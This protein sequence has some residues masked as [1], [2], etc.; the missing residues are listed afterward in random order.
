M[1]AEQNKHLWD[2]EMAER[3]GD[4]DDRWPEGDEFSFD[5]EAMIDELF[6]PRDEE[7]AMEGLTPEESKLLKEKYDGNPDVATDLREFQRL[8]RLEDREVRSRLLSSG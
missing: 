3:Y 1:L 6:D 8:M 7:A 4:V 5:E 2:Q